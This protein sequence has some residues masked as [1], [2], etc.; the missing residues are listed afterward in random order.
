MSIYYGSG[1]SVQASTQ[2]PINDILFSLVSDKSN[3]K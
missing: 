2:P 1:I 3:K